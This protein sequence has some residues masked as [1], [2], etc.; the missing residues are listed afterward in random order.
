MALPAPLQRHWLVLRRQLAGAALLPLAM[1][2]LEAWD[3]LAPPHLGLDQ[4]GVR[5]R[6]TDA[7]AGILWAPFLHADVWHLIANSVSLF[8]LGWIL[9]FSGRWL[10][11]RVVAFTGLSAGSGAWLFGSGG[12]V[13]L[14]ASG[15]IFGMLGFLIARG[16]VARRLHWTLI[17]FLVT[18][19]YLGSVFSLIKVDPRVSWSSHFWG[20]LGGVGLAWWMYRHHRY[21]AAPASLP[22]DRSWSAGLPAAS[23]P[24]RNL[25]FSLLSSSAPPARRAERNVTPRRAR[26]A[27]G[28][29]R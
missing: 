26:P 9:S 23:A 17:S 3:W 13:H 5:P 8:V 7:L 22:V 18:F 2:L 29:K 20:F 27:A 6:E 1:W 19:V 21:Q 25:V 10:Y 15:V 28:M 11:L 24:V 4:Y 16:W 12:M 14:G